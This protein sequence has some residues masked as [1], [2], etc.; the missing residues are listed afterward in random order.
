MEKKKEKTL[1]EKT[2]ERIVEFIKER[3]MQ[4]GDRLPSEHELTE[5]LKVG[6]GTLREAIKTLMSHNI[7][8]VRQ[9]AGTFV[10]YKNGIPEDPLG[11]ALEN[12]DDKLL[13]DML[14]VR[15]ILEP[16]IAELAAMNA[17][18]PQI[19]ELFRQCRQVEDLIKENK[20][21]IQVDSLFHQTVAECSGNR[22]IGKMMPIITSSIQ[23]KVGGTRDQFRK[24]TVAEHRIIAEAIAKRDARGAKYAMIA[25][26]NTT[27]SGISY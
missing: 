19:D 8:D 1:V 2:S 18:T 24:Q 22:I 27:R 20:S 10:S 13:L 23:L 26:L 6:R 15:M 16:E 5:M 14:D 17:T 7:L 4:P 11:L 9:G 21:Y 25:H 3:N 12:S